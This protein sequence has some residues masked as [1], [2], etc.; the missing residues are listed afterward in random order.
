MTANF[1]AKYKSKPIIVSRCGYTG[2]DGFE[3]SVP[4]DLITIF[5]EDLL[6]H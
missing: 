4:H 1:D 2:E 6:K 3:V 5:I